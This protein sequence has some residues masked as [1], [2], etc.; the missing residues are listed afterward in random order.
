MLSVA[1]T[2]TSDFDNLVESFIDID[3]LQVAMEQD[4]LD[5]AMRMCAVTI[6]RQDQLEWRLFIRKNGYLAPRRFRTFL[7]IVPVS[8]EFVDRHP[9]DVSTEHTLVMY[10]SFYVVEVTLRVFTYSD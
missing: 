2:R 3:I 4:I 10:C 5:F 8:K 6:E 7:N 9:H 1:Y